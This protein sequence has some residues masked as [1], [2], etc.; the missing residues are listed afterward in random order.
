[1]TN[2]KVLPNQQLSTQRC[3]LTVNRQIWICLLMTTQFSPGHLRQHWRM[4]TPKMADLRYVK[5]LKVISYNMRGFNQGRVAM[6]DLIDT[7]DADV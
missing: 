6:D 3:L 7:V 5:E 1:M 4:H 2:D